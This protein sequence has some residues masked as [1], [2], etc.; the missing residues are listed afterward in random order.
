MPKIGDRASA[1]DTEV[2]LA[3]G[4]S[5]AY[6]MD[7]QTLIP[8][9]NI[10]DPDGFPDHG[11][12][13]PCYRVQVSGSLDGEPV[14]VPGEDVLLEVPLV[15][16]KELDRTEIDVG[17]RFLISHP[18]KTEGGRWTMDFQARVDAEDLL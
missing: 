11:L 12:F 17:E 7:E 14:F 5:G 10:G 4:L 18:Q 6:A 3:P 1:P 16:E 9:E 13:L 15:L 2:V 8:A